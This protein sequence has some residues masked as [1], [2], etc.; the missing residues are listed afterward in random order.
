MDKDR[1][2]SIKRICAQFDD[3]VRTVHTIIWKELKMR[4][5]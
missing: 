4:K 3:S 5:I 2:V 1:R